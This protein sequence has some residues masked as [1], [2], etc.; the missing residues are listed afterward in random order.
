MALKQKVCLELF[1][2]EHDGIP[3]LVV[4]PHLG[5]GDVLLQPPL[6]SHLLRLRHVS[7]EDPGL[8]DM[9]L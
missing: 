6:G 5:V 7:R 3:V 4:Q 2:V 9:N 1:V 8:K